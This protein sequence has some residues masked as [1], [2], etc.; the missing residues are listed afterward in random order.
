MT[1]VPGKVDRGGMPRW[2]QIIMVCLVMSAVLHRLSF[3][4]ADP[5]LWGHLRFG[6]DIWRAGAVE[7]PDVYSYLSG[8]RPWINHEWLAEVIL[9]AVFTLGGSKA[10]VVF[11][12]LVALSITGL[13][14]RHLC[15]Q[16]LAPLRA[17]LVLVL[18]VLLLYLGVVVLRPQ[19]FT[20]LLLV[21]LLLALR[22]VEAGGERRLLILPPIFAL[23]INL[24]GGV[25]AGMAVLLAWYFTRLAR[26]LYA[27]RRLGAAVSAP[28]LKETIVVL[29]SIAATLLNPY[30]WRLPAFLLQPSTVVRPEIADWQPV[31]LMSGYGLTYLVVLG[32]AIV[33]LLF[34]RRERRPESLV[35]FLCIAPLPL[36]ANRHGALFGLLIPLLVGDHIADAWDRFSPASRPRES[37]RTAYALGVAAVA[38]SAAMLGTSASNFRCIQ[39]APPPAYPAR[40]V[41][42][43]RE[44]GIH[45]NLAGM[46]D[47]GEYVIW[48]LGPGVKVSIDGRRETVYSDR[49]YGESLAFLAGVGNWDAV[50][51][52][53][54]TQLALVS[55][56]RPTF[57]LMKRSP[58]WVPVYED[59]TAG[60]FVR[61]ASPLADRIRAV[62]PPAIAHDGAGL[63][64]P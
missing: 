49:V 63:C 25:L 11:K 54:A 43:L 17:G 57:N 28:D 62:T 42:V 61:D 55:K 22:A 48:H 29:G 30:G 51:R 44:S 2:L 27:A 4:V 19:L 47:W 34:S 40:A 26:T 50:L 3:T 38:V 32:V 64:F 58:G 8:D 33:A 20:Y 13:I 7:I 37:A 45:G 60:I 23:W 6:L 36:L 16:G 5:D 12:T 56:T 46:F 14:Y 35:L 18:A 41:A 31:R 59:L 10:L 53:E 39:I 15:K 9:A 52:N 24:H 1:P 21:I